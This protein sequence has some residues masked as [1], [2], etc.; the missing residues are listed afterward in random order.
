MGPTDHSMTTHSQQQRDDELAR[1]RETYRRSYQ[2]DW[3]NLAYR[4]HPRNPAALAYRHEREV[5][6][7]RLVNRLSIDI[8][9]A[10][11]LDVGCGYGGLL[12]LLLE[13]GADP[14]RLYG[15]DLAHERLAWA[16]H[17]TP[18]VCYVEQS[19]DQLPF[20]GAAFDMV[21]QLTLFSSI[22]DERLREAAAAEMV[23]VLRPG[24]VLLWFDIAG[25]IRTGDTRG[26][27]R[28]EVGRLF[29]GFHPIAARRLH[30]RLMG[31]LAGQRPLLNHLLG[32]W[33]LLRRTNVLLAFAKPPHAP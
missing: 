29:P 5:E 25:G 13:W 21:C 30:H 33:P 2:V 6:L 17:L 31:R 11:I 1:A 26:L 23:R 9:S 32:H 22:L 16:R 7:V 28:E 12:R 19:A 4:W 18:G 8:P 27:G 3:G 20:S 24:G 14:A 15:V 10:T